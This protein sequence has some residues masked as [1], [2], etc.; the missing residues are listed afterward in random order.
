MSLNLSVF[1][2]PFNES[3]LFNVSNF[4]YALES[5]NGVT[6]NGSNQVTA[7]ENQ[8]TGGNFA[9]PSSPGIIVSSGLDENSKLTLDGTAN[10]VLTSATNIQFPPNHTIISVFKFT[11]NANFSAMAFSHIYNANPN[12]E[13]GIYASSGY[14]VRMRYNGIDTFNSAVST[15]LN[16]VA[17]VIQ[18]EESLSNHKIYINGGSPWINNTQTI[19]QITNSGVSG[20]GRHVNAA[21]YAIGDYY[22]LYA[23]ANL[24]IEEINN[25]VSSRILSRFPTLASLWNPIV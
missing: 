17:I 1:G 24:T 6:V 12:V 7:W 11:P 13:M 4:L 21:Q 20:I 5:W 9:P 8:G 10:S 23:K 18:R 19:S 16:N 2:I 15:A 22:A 3:L 14:R 25:L